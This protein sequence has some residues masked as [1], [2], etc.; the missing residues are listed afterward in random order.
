LEIRKT[1]RAS[2][3]TPPRWKLL[4]SMAML[5]L[6]LARSWVDTIM[7]PKSLES[8]AVA[9]I[10]VLLI[11]STMIA[12]GIHYKFTED[13]LVVCFLWMPLRCVRW[14]RIT[15]ALFAHAWADPKTRYH[16]ITNPGAVTGQII[17]VTINGCPRWHPIL[18]TRWWHSLL[19]PF[20]SFT[21]W[22]PYDRKEYFIEAFKKHYPDLEMQPLD[23]WK[24]F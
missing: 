21:I 12:S 15:H 10:E 6:L 13:F 11:V 1:V 16:R 7:N 14:H 2:I 4:I 23:D 3:I 20:R 24:K 19:H 5:S 18:T 9:I 8:L 17:Y 22:L